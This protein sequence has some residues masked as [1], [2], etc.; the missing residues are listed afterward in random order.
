MK[1]ENSCNKLALNLLN[2]PSILNDNFNYINTLILLEV[3]K[4]LEIPTKENQYW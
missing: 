2:R 3:Q 1:K 4:I